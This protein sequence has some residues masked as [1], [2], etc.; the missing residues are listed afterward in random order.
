[1]RRILLLLALASCRSEAP[2]SDPAPPPG[3]ARP[4]SAAGRWI[5]LQRAVD[6][7]VEQH[8]ARVLQDPSALAE[9]GPSLPARIEKIH[10]QAGS[11]VRRGDVLFTV[12]MPEA[13]TAA[14]VQGST[15]PLVRA[16]EGRRE[17]L[18]ALKAEGLARASDLFTV[19][20][21]LARAQ[22]ERAR[23]GA[24]LRGLGGGASELRSPIDGVVTELQGAV[25]EWRRPEEGPLARVVEPRGKRVEARLPGAPSPGVRYVLQQE[26]GALALT[27]L[28]QAPRVGEEAQGYL[29]WFALP[30]GAAVAPSMTA[31]VQAL[32][33]EGA[34]QVEARALLYRGGKALVA[35]RKG[36]R[37]EAVEVEV[38]RVQGGSAW[39]KAPLEPGTPVATEPGQ[40]LAP[41]TP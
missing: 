15:G 9:V 38:L 40:A 13:V 39:I 30:E 29:V 18:R 33:P 16:L 10:T 14:A 26:G 22:A 20:V 36:E 27:L 28:E 3:A 8:P 7:P 19:E 32:P 17:Q 25:G 31:Q 4:V 24:V 5:P 11:R 34:M 37:P 6:A 1:M 12:L 2:R 41:E 23:A 21:E 35:A